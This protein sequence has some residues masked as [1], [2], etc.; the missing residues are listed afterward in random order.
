MC[1]LDT[2]VQRLLAGTPVLKISL[3]FGDQFGR[4]SRWHQRESGVRATS[5]DRLGSLVGGS[6]WG[7]RHDALVV[8]NHP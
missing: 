5:S 7:Q 4:R 1:A 2:V 8:W 6:L 3:C